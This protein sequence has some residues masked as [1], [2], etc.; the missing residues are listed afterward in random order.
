MLTQQF[1]EKLEFLFED[2]SVDSIFSSRF[3]PA[4]SLISMLSDVWEMVVERTA[5]IA[6]GNSVNFAGYASNVYALISSTQSSI[7]GVSSRKFFESYEEM[8]EKLRYF[9]KLEADSDSLEMLVHGL[10]GFANL[11]DEFL[12]N[13]IPARA[14]PLLNQA[15][16]SWIQLLAVGGTLHTVRQQL[17]SSAEYETGSSDQSSMSILLPCADNYSAFVSRLVAIGRLYSEI[18]RLLDTAEED[19]PLKII[20]IES[21][22]LW[23]KV[24]GESRVLNL[25][26]RFV[27]EAAGFIYRN[28][29]SEGKISVVPRNV[30]ALDSVIG[31]RASLREQGVDTREMDQQIS[32]ASIHIAK[33]LNHLLE[34]Q[35][36]V[37][38]NGRSM[39]ASSEKLRQELESRPWPLLEQS[40]PDAITEGISEAG[41]SN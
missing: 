30:Q 24:F 13:P 26:S 28:Y 6:E 5:G 11:Y 21:G 33:S 27:E 1:V 39:S 38:V 32:G 23:L 35:G 37:T 7:S 10:D 22:S 9:S 14:F 29:T 31:L 8:I 41:I 3:R 19:F 16:K 25:I 12:S 15:N 4:I 17:Q 20:K 34:R 40:A 36:S 18:C 2:N